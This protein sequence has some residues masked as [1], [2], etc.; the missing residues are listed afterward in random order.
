MLTS[1]IPLIILLAIISGILIVIKV[2]INKSMRG[3][4]EKEG[5]NKGVLVALITNS[6]LLGWFRSGVRGSRLAKNE[7]KDENDNEIEVFVVIFFKK[8][9]VLLSKFKKLIDFANIITYKN[10]RQQKWN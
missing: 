8:T 7:L 5:M 9:G 3:P 6:W 2:Y 1:F 4:A 10:M